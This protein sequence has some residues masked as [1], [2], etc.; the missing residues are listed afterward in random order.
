M[1][2][3]VYSNIKSENSYGK[4]HSVLKRSNIENFIQI[5]KS[6]EVLKKGIVLGEESDSIKSKEEF[7]DLISYIFQSLTNI[8]Y[9]T[10]EILEFMCNVINAGTGDSQIFSDEQKNEIIEFLKRSFCFVHT[11]YTKNKLWTSSSKNQKV[12]KNILFGHDSKDHFNMGLVIG[13]TGSKI[14][15]SYPPFK[16]D[17]KSLSSFAGVSTSKNTKTNFNSL[18]TTFK[19]YN[20]NKKVSNPTKENTSV[21]SILISNP[22]IRVGSQNSLELSTFF[23]GLTTLELNRSYPYFNAT[24]IIPSISSNDKSKE[25]KVSSNS[26]TINN[27]LFGNVKNKTSNY[28]NLSGNKVNGFTQTNMSIFTSPQTMVNLDEPVGYS[29][30][31]PNENRKNTVIDPTQPLMTIK[32]FNINSAPTKGLMSYKT[33]RMSLVLHDRSRMND[34]QAFIK[35]DLLGAF[36]AEIAV[37]YGWSNP[38]QENVKNPIGYF[39]GN[40]KILEKYMI[41]NSSLSMDNTGQVNIDLSLAMKG[42]HEFKNQ[43]IERSVRNRI[44]ESEFENLL[45]KIRSLQSQLLDKDITINTNQF[46]GIFSET[47]RLTPDQRDYLISYNSPRIRVLSSIKR[48]ISKYITI[49]QGRTGPFSDDFFEFQ[50]QNLGKNQIKTLIEILTNET[51]DEKFFDSTLNIYKIKIINNKIDFEE[52][53]EILK[54]IYLYSEELVNVISEI[55]KQDNLEA[56]NERKI[57]ESVMGS[58]EYIDHFYPTSNKI[59]SQ[60]KNPE[61]YISLGSIINSIVQ[62]YIANP[63]GRFE[64]RFDEIQTIF[65]TAN[66]K[67]ALMANE[68][69]SSFLINKK[70]LGEL[71]KDIFSNNTVITPESLITQILL[72]LV[73]VEDNISLGLSDLY[74]RKKGKTSYKSPVS[75]KQSL[76]DKKS[77]KS[78]LSKTLKKIYY[79]DKPSEDSKAEFRMP[80]I[81]INF[82]CLSSDS[83]ESN[84]NSKSILRI[85][86]FDRIDSPFSSSSEILNKIY[87]NNLKGS[88]GDLIA[89]RIDYQNNKREG[90]TRKNLEEFNVKHK[91]ELET[92][93]SREYIIKNKNGTYSINEDKLRG[94]KNFIGEIKDLYKEIYPSL[95]FGM[96][97]SIMIDA[98]VTTINDN[99]LSTIFMTRPERNDQSLINSRINPS[100]PLVIMPSQAS[101]EIFGCPWVNFGQSIFLDFGTGTTIDNRYIVTG[102]DHNLSPGKFT[103]RL[104]LSYGDNFGQLQNYTDILNSKEAEEEK[105][106]KDKLSKTKSSSKVKK[107]FKLTIDPGY[108]K[109]KEYDVTLAAQKS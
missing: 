69:L 15:G 29:Q 101:I 51:Y 107:V 19:E 57:L 108:E 81:H 48:N 99:K 102:I 38:D 109:L 53:L 103:T 54:K 18:K 68:N 46:K 76:I 49:I 42:P 100:L 79:G 12:L 66:D 4:I 22:S 26:T 104:T 83:L 78:D 43:K 11:D 71:L 32:S 87:T 106:I 39:I 35:P 3:R 30:N 44:T 67:S 14:I 52:I 45:S 31:N 72:K 5:V 91:K 6:S 8:G 63:K 89:N 40:S 70:M 56:V 77:F 50:I 105:S 16:R 21:S 98:N 55:V 97:N 65:Y 90:D 93:L 1:S 94:R 62:N 58:V 28:D 34:V 10:Y 7:Y 23:N 74:E 80:I 60:I 85:S 17:I 24:F 47:S 96:Q 82:D 13:S 84:K 73:Q 27:F 9:T 37:E 61:D 92:L 2:G 20:L 41:V 64:S 88:F 95:T 33:A 86:V 36:G 75:P 25:L 59:Y